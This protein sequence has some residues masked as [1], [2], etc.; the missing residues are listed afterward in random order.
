MEIKQSEFEEIR[1]NR[2]PTRTGPVKNGRKEMYSVGSR[3]QTQ[4]SEDIVN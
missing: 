3:S 2:Q 1:G 4:F